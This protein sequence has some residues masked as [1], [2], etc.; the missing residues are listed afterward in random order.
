MKYTILTLL[1]TLFLFSAAASAQ[2]APAPKPTPAPAAKPADISGKWTVMADAQGTTIQIGVEFK[3]TGD[4]FTGSTA[5]DMG[6]GTIDGGKV[7]G[8]AF[9]ATLHADV[10]GN[11][12]DF[13][14]DGTV[15]G[16]KITGSFTNAQLGSIPFTATKNK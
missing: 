2:T 3:Q 12:M 6:N 16:D 8:K 1:F 9:T 7:T 14:M 4:T 15:D 13:R 10:Q 5:S 11:P